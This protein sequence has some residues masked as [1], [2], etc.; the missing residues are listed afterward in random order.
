MNKIKTLIAAAIL[1]VGLNAHAV[2]IGSLTHAQFQ[3][4]PPSGAEATA[5]YWLNSIEGTTFTAADAVNLSIA[6]P[7]DVSG[8]MYLVL[9]YGRGPGG[10]N[11][12]TTPGGGYEAHDVASV[13]THTATPQ[14]PYGIG[15]LSWAIAFGP[16]D[17]VPD[18]GTTLVLLGGSLIGVGALRRRFSK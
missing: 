7:I 4:L 6:S 10:R 13:D 14:Q 12:T 3:A 17:S 18:A 8:Y 16:K 11:A 15:G 9:H 2:L 1:T 5:A